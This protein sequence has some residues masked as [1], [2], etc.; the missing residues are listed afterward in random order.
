MVFVGPPG[1]TSRIF[2]WGP[3]RERLDFLLPIYMDRPGT[4]S[5]RLPRTRRMLGMLRP[6]KRFSPGVTRFI[7]RGSLEVPSRIKL[8]I[9]PNLLP[10][11]LVPVLVPVQYQ[12]ASYPVILRRSPL[13]KQK[14]AH[15]KGWRAISIEKGGS[16]G[17]TRT[18]N[19]AVN[20]R[21]LHH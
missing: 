15:P 14:P 18:C 10:A 5:Y 7:W 2:F 9:A 17:R 20:S 13:Q 6:S 21:S 16:P 19:L 12:S 11:D 1:A 4:I 3:P 8:G